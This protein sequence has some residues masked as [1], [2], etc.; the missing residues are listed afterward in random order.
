MQRRDFCKLIAATAAATTVPSVVEAAEV[1]Q[2]PAADAAQSSA[3]GSFDTLTQDYA[4]FCSTP[5]SERVFYALTGRKILQEKLDEKTWTPTAWG[6]APKLPVPGGSWDGVPMDSPIAGLSGDGPYQPT[7]SGVVS[8][9]QVWHLGTLESAMRSGR[10]RL[11]CAQH[12]YAGLP[13]E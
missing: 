12:V 2:S 5:A 1:A 11:V 10:R 4:K 3:P 9:R 7:C 13:L 8:R 6:E